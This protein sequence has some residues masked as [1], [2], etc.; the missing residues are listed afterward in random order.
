MYL[1]TLAHAVRTLLNDLL[2]LLSGLSLFLVPLGLYRLSLVP[3]FHCATNHVHVADEHY[4]K[5]L[6]IIFFSS[7][8]LAYFCFLLFLALFLLRFTPVA[9]LFIWFL[10]TLLNVI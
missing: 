5:A 3:L 2:A 6:C 1:V 4:L 9:L 10:S 7:A 8:L